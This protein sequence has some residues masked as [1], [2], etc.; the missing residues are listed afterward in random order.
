MRLPAPPPPLLL[1]G[2][3]A[4]PPNWNAPADMEVRPHSGFAT[5]L[6]APSV[7]TDARGRD[8]IHPLPGSPI[9]DEA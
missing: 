9:G 1:A 8:R 4:A 2:A 7:R 3:C 5:R 6:P